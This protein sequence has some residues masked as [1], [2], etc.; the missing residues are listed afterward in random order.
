MAEVTLLGRVTTTRQ[1]VLTPPIWGTATLTLSGYSLAAYSGAYL[2]EV[3]EN[4]YALFSYGN[5]GVASQN[6][7]DGTLSGYSFESR[8][9][10]AAALELSL[11]T[12]TATGTPEQ[13][14]EAELELSGYSLSATATVSAGGGVS[15]TYTGQ[16]ALSALGGAQARGTLPRPTVAA[17]GTAD[18]LGQVVGVLPRPTLLASGY[19]DNLGQVVGVL[20]TLTPTPNGRVI[21]VLPRAMFVATGGSQSVVY[22][23]YSVTLNS[24]KEGLQAYTTHYTNY[25]FDRILRFGGKYYGVAADGLF[26]LSGDTFNG[27]AIVSVVQTAPTD[28]KQRTMK[29]PVSMYMSGRV[30][31][32]FKVS[33]I[34]A[35]EDTNRYSYKP[36]Q[37][38]GSRTHRVMF[39]KGVR[40]RYIAY[41]LTNTDGG[42]FEL[43]DLTP[44]T[45]VMERRTA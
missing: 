19:G 5:V 9:G 18:R 17:S 7:F 8:C 43:D 36:V 32:D 3:L 24:G 44:E 13:I 15:K 12:F 34:S 45:V 10:G 23:A 40:A 26:E 33:V 6:G 37:K 38:T 4:K 11:P 21:A 28:F 1:G 25:P 39:G 27:T 35:E 42:D 20:P 41:A 2:N 22:E 30:G 14:G 16:Y 31:A 29:R